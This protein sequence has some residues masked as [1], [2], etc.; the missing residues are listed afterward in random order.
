MNWRLTG[1]SAGSSRSGTELSP[2]SIQ[3]HKRTHKYGIEIPKSVEETYEIDK[4]T[5]TTFW[6]DA[7]EKEMTNVHIA[8]DIMAEPGAPPPDHQFICCHMIFEARLVAGGYATKAP[9]TLTYAS[10]VSRKTVRIALLIAA[11]NN[12]DIWAADVLN[13]YITVPCQE[14]I[15]TTL[16]KDFGD[17]CGKKAIVVRAL[18]GLKSSGA[19]FRVHLAG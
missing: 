17:D 18:Y 4:A 7:I 11:L 10:I 3:Y 13:A 6:C 9:A 2:W 12:V 5:G 16:G 8:F 14:K 15:W 1:G 19:A